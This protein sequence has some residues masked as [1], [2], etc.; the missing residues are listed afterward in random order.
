MG[1]EHALNEQPSV[2]AFPVAD[3]RATPVAPL[4]MVTIALRAYAKPPQ[5]ACT[6]GA[7]KR[8]RLKSIE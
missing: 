2:D 3:K 7:V 6:Q 4:D 8:C 1:R 5:G